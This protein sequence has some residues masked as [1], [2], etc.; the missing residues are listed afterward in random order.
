I[1]T[2]V[3]AANDCARG[4]VAVTTGVEDTDTFDLILPNCNVSHIDATARIQ[5]DAAWLVETCFWATNFDQGRRVA[6]AARSIDDDTASVDDT[7][8][9]NA[10]AEVCYVDVAPGV[11]CNATWTSEPGRG[12]GDN[13]GRLDVAVAACWKHPN[14]LALAPWASG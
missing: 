7:A 13:A 9:P 6:A 8:S 3:V 10:A 4:N 1:K 11:Q 12:T 5:C 2:G 14:A